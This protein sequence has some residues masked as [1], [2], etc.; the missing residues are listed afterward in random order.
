[1][2]DTAQ[3]Y[4]HDAI[5]L[6]K[7]ESKNSS[8]EKLGECYL[9]LATCGLSGTERQE[10]IQLA[11]YTLKKPHLLAE[12]LLLQASLSETKGDFTQASVLFE[13]AL[14]LNERSPEAKVG[15]E[16]MTIM[17]K[18]KAAGQEMEGEAVQA[19]DRAGRFK[20]MGNGCFKQ[21]N[22]RVAIRWY[23]KAQQLDA[24]DPSFALN[25]I[26]ALL[27]LKQHR[28]AVDEA[29]RVLAMQEGLAVGQKVR[30]GGLK[31]ANYNGKEG[32]LVGPAGDRWTVE[33]GPKRLKIKPENLTPIKRE[34]SLSQLCKLHFR[35]G[36]ALVLLERF[37]QAV[38]AYK[39]ALVIEPSNGRI[40]DALAQVEGR[41]EADADSDDDAVVLEAVTAHERE[42]AQ[43]QREQEEREQRAYEQQQQQQQ[44]MSAVERM[45]EGVGDQEEEG[46]G[47]PAARS[48]L[49]VEVGSSVAEEAEPEPESSADLLVEQPRYS[50][51]RC[52]REEG[53]DGQQHERIQVQVTFAAVHR[54][55]TA[56]AVDL[57]T[58]S[59]ELVVSSTRSPP[60]FDPVCIPLPAPVDCASCAAKFSKREGKLSVSLL[61]TGL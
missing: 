24:T 45:F 61:E 6:L 17:V 57:H 46:Q 32:V 58:T 30:V 54:A 48:P 2:L 56:K 52:G 29:D 43:A 9:E 13:A 31:A 41:M 33:V 59:Q 37:G 14:E 4:W 12:A 35:R 5:K 3:R 27:K 22:P 42:R 1:M 20:M 16:R 44:P 10:T 26:Q 25:I 15:L 39:A 8:S 11:V 34:L 28:E 51:E 60:T 18:A 21:G 47:G 49:V 40:T 55:R 38:E 23:R 19:A 36:E 7:K 53:A 50:V